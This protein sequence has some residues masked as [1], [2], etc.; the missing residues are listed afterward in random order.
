MK[1]NYNQLISPTIISILIVI[2]SSFSIILHGQIDVSDNNGIVDIKKVNKWNITFNGGATLLWGDLSDET[3]NPFTKYFSDQQGV[4]Y[5][6]MLSRRIGKTFTANLQYIGGNLQGYRST[7]SNGDTANLSFN[8]KIN[9][10]NFNIEVDLMNLVFEPKEQRFFSAY[11]KAGVGYLFYKPVVTHT[12]DGSAVFSG[13]GSSLDL[14]WGWGVK[15]DI[16]KH[17]SIR[18]EN[19]FHH[20]LADDVDGH[21][22][23][24]SNANDIYNYTSLGVTYR[25]FQNPKQPK[26]P[27]EDKI[28]PTDTAVAGVEAEKKPFELT[29]A[30]NFPANMHP[31][32]TSD[33]TLRISKGDLSGA[34]KLQQNIPDGFMVKEL[35][36]SDAEFEFK[37]QIMT[38]SWEEFPDKETLNI[39]YRLISN[40]A[41]MGGHSI[42]GI[43]F[44]L[45]DDVNQIRQFKKTIDIISEPVIAQNS[46]LQSNEINTKDKDTAAT[47]TPIVKAHD[48]KKAEGLKY[49]VQVYA[50]YGGTTSSKLL[51]RRLNLDYAVK[52]DYQGD[53]AKYTSGEF[54]TYDEAAAYKKKLRETSVPGAFVV[55]FYEGERTKDIQEAIAIENGTKTDVNRPSIPMGI[56]YRIQIMAASKNLSN[57]LVREQTGC[58]KTFEKVTHNGLYKYEVGSYKSYSEAKAAL[59][60]IKAEVSDAFIVKYIDGKRL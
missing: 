60:I 44:Y 51:E 31:Y 38:Y 8:S 48:N 7:W 16:S 17:I 12:N 45:Q 2:F 36:S 25:I 58:S 13:S 57:E 56:I 34:A 54:A 10:I 21:G 11:L 46:N 33:V 26:L 53:Y 42:P 37:N 23:I 9:D 29:I 43:L 49:R 18:F 28:V 14:P 41:S 47:E 22:T 52:Q 32:D 27:K 5:G 4:G 20:V 1:L 40:N 3:A 55:G 50:V 15:S 19:T 35:I 39:T 30:A 24:Y 59:I 6:I